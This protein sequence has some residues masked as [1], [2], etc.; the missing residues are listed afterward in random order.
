MSL[1]Y[2]M[3]SWRINL[4]WTAG[5]P[6][7]YKWRYVSKQQ[8]DDSS[9]T[10]KEHV[11]V[12]EEDLKMLL[13]YINEKDG[14]SPWNLMMDNST[15]TL[16]F[17]VWRRDSEFGPT[18]YRS[19]AIF[20]NMEPELLRDFFW[21]DDFR[22]KWDDML[23]YFRKLRE[24]SD[25]GT[26]ILHWIRKFPVFGS[27]REYIIG[28]RLWVSGSTYYCVSKSLPF[29]GTPRSQ[30]PKRANP[31]YSSWRIRA[32]ESRNGGQSTASEVLV[33][34]FEDMGIQNMLV[35]IGIQ[36][37]MW[38]LINKL[39]QGLRSYKISRLNRVP[40]S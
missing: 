5:M 33:F 27:P 22:T 32:V 15:S 26:V 2:S 35:K 28:R 23:V 37:E 21:D 3:F 9:E 10:E 34:H 20:E 38:K 4:I 13:A 39:E 25:T 6:H 24:Y 17:R 12:T 16:S 31:Y 1:L 40:S 8:S 19:L 18:Q 14:G 36:R 11:G 7:R 30:R 29:P